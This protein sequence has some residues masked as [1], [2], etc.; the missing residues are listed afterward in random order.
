[1]ADAH[2]TATE[3]GFGP[4]LTSYRLDHLPRPPRRPVRDVPA[5]FEPLFER[6]RE[7]GLPAN[8]VQA[9]R[10]DYRL[11]LELRSSPTMATSSG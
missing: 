2:E 3:A 1:M 8:Q 9:L 7:L 4:A 5:D 6:I 11:Q 10:D